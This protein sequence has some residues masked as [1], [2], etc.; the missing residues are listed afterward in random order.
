[1]HKEKQRE[2]QIN[3]RDSLE[4]TLT[5][6]KVSPLAFPDIIVSVSRLLNG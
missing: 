5:N 4:L 1:M 2:Q 6:G 3:G